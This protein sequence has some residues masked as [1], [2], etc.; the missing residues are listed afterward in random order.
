MRPNK[1]ETAV[2]YS[3]AS[4]FGGFSG[5]PIQNIFFVLHSFKYGKK[6]RGRLYLLTFSPNNIKYR[7]S[8]WGR[9]LSLS[10]TR[11]DLTKHSG[12][13]GTI[14]QQQTSGLAV[15]LKVPVLDR[16]ENLNNVKV[17]E[18]RSFY[19]YIYIFCAIVSQ[20]FFFS[21]PLYDVKTFMV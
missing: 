13:K 21:S 2:R 10:T 19:I 7:P 12:P 15:A 14:G 3:R 20:E 9:Y 6:N 1:D 18:L 16:L 8:L 5:N 4:V 11:Q 17:R